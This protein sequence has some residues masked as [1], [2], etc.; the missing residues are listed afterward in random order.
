[1]A[2]EDASN[3]LR[4]GNQGQRL[5]RG[6]L[7]PS[8]AAQ[9]ASNNETVDTKLEKVASNIEA[10]DEILL[11]IHDRLEEMVEVLK[12]LETNGIKTTGSSG[13]GI[14]KRTGSVLGKIAGTIAAPFLF[15]LGLIKDLKD[16]FTGALR[17]IIELPGRILGGITKGIGAIIKTPFKLIGRLFESKDMKALVALSQEQLNTQKEILS[18]L[19]AFKNAYM[20]D[21]KRERR[22]NLDNLERRR[23]NRRSPIVTPVSVTDDQESRDASKDSAQQ[24]NKTLMDRLK[25]L[26][27]NAVA[28]FG[29]LNIAG[30]LLRPF[31]NLLGRGFRGARN[32]I[33]GRN[34]PTVRNNQIRSGNERFGRTNNNTNPNPNN[35]SNRTSNR[36]NNS[37]VRNRVFNAAK[38]VAGNV[39]RFG[40]GSLLAPLSYL[41]SATPLADGTMS[42]LQGP[43]FP[44]DRSQEGSLSEARQRAVMEKISTERAQK[45]RSEQEKMIF[46][47]TSARLASQS[48]AKVEID[49]KAPIE[50]IVVNGDDIGG[51]IDIEQAPEVKN[52]IEGLSNVNERSKLP[53]INIERIEPSIGGTM[54]SPITGDSPAP[55]PKISSGS[56]NLISGQIARIEGER[57]DQS[58]PNPIANNGSLPNVPFNNSP[59]TDSV[60]KADNQ[61]TPNEKEKNQ[62]NA[63][64]AISNAIQTEINNVSNSPKY[65][66]DFSEQSTN[67][68][69]NEVVTKLR[70]KNVSYQLNNGNYSVIENIGQKMNLTPKDL[71]NQSTISQA[72]LRTNLFPDMTAVT[73]N[74]SDMT[75]TGQGTIVP[76]RMIEGQ[77]NLS[78][79]ANMTL[80]STPNN[81]FLQE[82]EN[83]IMLAGNKG[84]GD[85][86]AAPTT[87]MDAR[88]DNSVNNTTVVNASGITTVDN[89]LDKVVPI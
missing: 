15:P 3:E 4:R 67:N 55:I 64:K 31:G 21:Q 65:K 53:E 30:R 72:I 13:E 61:F 83:S 73:P 45:E 60:E 81:P 28:V 39:L 79:T 41:S 71:Y 18:T 26:L 5:D 70:N 76:R 25:D 37:S 40:T 66:N 52:I 85:F 19:N 63:V 16:G 35:T 59:R 12:R 8:V 34:R 46:D 56:A 51:K 38:N 7:L 50:V 33:T 87:V 80:P 27:F 49:N 11:T 69:L 58:S 32:I 2:I 84:S 24:D 78:P 77:N 89:S 88:A 22:Q 23:D 14:A 44:G 9:E 43:N 29:S 75:I 42:G 10:S 82:M 86:I 6:L 47:E 62:L 54:M 74:M 20:E 57:I 36:A 17:S 48:L 1:M 68:M